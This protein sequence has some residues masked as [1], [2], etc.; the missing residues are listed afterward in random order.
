MSCLRVVTVQPGH[1]AGATQIPSPPAGL[2]HMPAIP[3]PRAAGMLHSSHPQ[4]SP[5]DW[6]GRLWAAEEHRE[7]E[8]SSLPP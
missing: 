6:R 3:T 4:T 7:P 8:P 5:E 2:G 1:A